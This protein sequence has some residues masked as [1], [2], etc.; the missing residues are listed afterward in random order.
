MLATP[1]LISAAPTVGTRLPRW[2]SRRVPDALSSPAMEISKRSNHV[3]V[4]GYG[5]NG[6]T[7]AKV[8][9][10]AGIGYVV[11]ELD[12]DTVRKAVSDGI[13]MIFGDSTRREILEHAGIEEAQIVVYAISDLQAVR[14]SIALSREL[15]PALHIVVRTRQISEIEGLTRV[16]ADEVIAEEFESAIE[17]FTRVLRRYHVPRNIIRT[18]TR[19]LRG[20]GYKML[21]SPAARG[22]ISAELME[23]LEAGTT[24]LFRL[25]EDSPVAGRTLRDLHL[26]RHTGATIVAIVRNDVPMPSPAP[27]V[28]LEIGDTLVL[29]GSHEQVDTAMDLL[30]GPR[31]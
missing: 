22:E 31:R 5:H 12:G 28:A 4:M 2:L 26:R 29:V 11:I 30:E 23:A 17:I 20:E 3:I 25:S 16:G 8:L 21:R 15:N 7:L 14:R 13:P 18:Q 19:L 6:S 1:A 10:E 27:E 9:K 24:E